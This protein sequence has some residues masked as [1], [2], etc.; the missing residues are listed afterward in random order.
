MEMVKESLAAT[1][2]KLTYH[3]QEVISGKIRRTATWN[4]AVKLAIGDIIIFLDDD[5]VLNK[6]YIYQILKTYHENTEN[7]II[8][9]MGRFKNQEIKKICKKNGHFCIP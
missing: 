7:G 9:V 6:Y 8:G 4:K 3:R 5:V 2:I 1:G